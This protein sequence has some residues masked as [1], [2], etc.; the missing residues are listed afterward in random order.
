MEM[1][2]T[3]ILSHHV[4]KSTRKEIAA[5]HVTHRGGKGEPFH[6]WYAYLEGYSSEFVKQLL[7]NH[8]L[9]AKKI[10]DPFA[11]T[12]TTPIVLASLDIDCGFC[13]VNPAMRLVIDTKL[14]VGRLSAKKRYELALQARNL[15]SK[16]P[17]L[18]KKAKS[19][20]ALKNDFILNFGQSPFFDE[21][22]FKVALGL[23]TINDQ[24]NECN[25]LLGDLLTVA[26]LSQLVT[27]SR[28]KRN[29]DVR[30]KT[31]KELEKGI[32]PLLEATSK[33]LLLI[34]DDCESAPIL[35]GKGAL[36][37]ANAKDLNTFSKFQADGVITSPPYLNG[38]NYFRN[39]KLELWY[40]RFLSNGITLRTFRDLAITSGINDVGSTQGRN[41]INPAVAKIVKELEV[42]AYDQRI[43]RMVAGY[44]ED[45][46][47]VLIGLGG[48]CRSGASI[49]IDIGDSRYGGVHVQTDK[50]LAAI[51]EDLHMTH[52][53][54]IRLRTRFSKD[55]TPL[56]QSLIV[57]KTK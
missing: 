28:L 53:E 57:L 52:V 11:G 19:D 7:S 33:Q 20:E 25:P 36:L 43:P 21:L 12:G 18:I 47:K 50:L 48:A 27:S 49:C 10:I 29:G 6:D 35:S 38:T 15:S 3:E 1:Q 41:S 54:T 51:A 55:K 44:F 13:E 26:V 32:F 40:G 4:P 14:T 45:M 34:A 56:S 17:T 37:T 2:S 16:L 42:N 23:R 30:Y 24:V 8:F 39:T 9:D 5:K 46:Q 22:T 31:E